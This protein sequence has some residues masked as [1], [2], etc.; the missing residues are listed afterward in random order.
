M[1]I[2][3]IGIRPQKSAVSPFGDSVYADYKKWCDEYF[4][5]PHRKE[6]R[7]IGGLF[8]D[9]L[10]EWGFEKSFAFMQAVWETLI[11]MLMRRIL[12]LRKNTPFTEKEL[13]FQQYRRGRYAEFN[14]AIDRGTIFGLQSGVGRIESILMSLPPKVR[15]V[16]DWKPE[17]GLSRR[18]VIY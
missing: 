14:L 16:Y 9:D 8:F 7:G 13:F 2:A 5:L 1:K 10:N 15:W 4:Y 3:H 17:P 6:T 12:E 11:S 18:K